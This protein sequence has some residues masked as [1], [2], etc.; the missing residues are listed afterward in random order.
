MFSPR[1]RLGVLGDAETGSEPVDEVT[2]FIQ[3][4]QNGVIRPRLEAMPPDHPSMTY[5]LV[6]VAALPSMAETDQ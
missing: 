5:S 2:G 3:K 1:G 6:M 4:N